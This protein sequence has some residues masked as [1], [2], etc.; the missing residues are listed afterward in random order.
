M[1][2]ARLHIWYWKET[3]NQGEQ[4]LRCP[5]TQMGHWAETL[6]GRKKIG[7]AVRRHDV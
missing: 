7:E 4:N 5:I 3:I 6:D 1:H 2:E